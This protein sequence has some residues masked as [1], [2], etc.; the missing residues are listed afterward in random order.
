MLRPRGVLKQQPGAAAPD[1]NLHRFG[2][3]MSNVDKTKGSMAATYESLNRRQPVASSVSEDAQR[4]MRLLSVQMQNQDPLNPL[5]NAQVTSQ[6]AQINTVT[7]INQLNQSIQA[8]TASQLRSEAFTASTMIGKNVVVQTNELGVKN[9]K[10]SGTFALDGRASNVTVEVLDSNRRVVDSF[11][12]GAKDKGVHD[13]N[14]RTSRRPSE[15]QFSFRV[16]AT[17]NKKDVPA[18]PLARANVAAVSFAKSAGGQLM[19][20]NGMDVPLSS[21]WR[22]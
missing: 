10:A 14:W 15:G 12:L 13:F 19:L 17:A 11:S 7:G 4:F 20:D 6:V 1:S 18:T 8:L 2:A 21:V 9:G 3:D 5:D 22:F 16:V